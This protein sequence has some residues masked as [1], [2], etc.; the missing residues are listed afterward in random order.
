MLHADTPNRDSLACDIMEAVRPSVDAWLFDWI[1]KELFRRSDFF[2]KP[3][4]NCRL[5]GPFAAKLCQTAP[6]W[7]QAV[8]PVAEWVART[9][10]N[11]IPRPKSQRGIA[12]PLTQRHGSEG[13]S[14]HYVP[15]SQSAPRPEGIC[16]NCGALLKEGK[17]HCA[18]CSVPIS[19]AILI[20]AAKL[21]RIATHSPDAEALRA[22]TQRRQ[23]AARKA[24]RSSDQPAWLTGQFYIK[25]IQ[26]RLSEL[27]SSVIGSTLS[28]SKPYAAEIRAGATATPSSELAGTCRSSL[29]SRNDRTHP[30]TRLRIPNIPLHQHHGIPWWTS[31]G[32]TWSPG[33]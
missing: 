9:L 14:G 15:V 28:V 16:R 22:A 27:T 10:W 11:T 17:N 13:G 23:V 2:Q 29:V 30:S 21:G 24:W 3:N 12:T 19:R 33:L 18:S 7:G 1:R 25:E 26:P 31:S 32:H 8:A 20:E 5:M 6:A 4:G